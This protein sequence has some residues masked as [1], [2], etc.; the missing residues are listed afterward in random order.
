MVN[1]SL[2]I[3]LPNHPPIALT[4][5]GDLGNLIDYSPLQLT[6]IKLRSH[7][8]QFSDLIAH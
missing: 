5:L 6:I 3:E 8:G 4:G 2:T 1:L 7:P